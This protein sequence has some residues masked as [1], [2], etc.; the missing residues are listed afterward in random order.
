MINLFK[1][2]FRKKADSPSDRYEICISGSGGQG[3]ILAG[4][5]L[6]KAA[7]KDGKN[8]VQTQSYGP[9]SRGGASRCEVVVSEG[10]IDYPKLMGVDL[11]L[12]LTQEALTKQIPNL[13]A[14]A[15]T[16]YDS[17]YIKEPPKNLENCFAIPFTQLAM[18]EF[19]NRLVANM[20]ALG[21]LVGI[22]CVVSRDA[23]QSAL[24]SHVRES[25]RD[26]NIKALLRGFEEADRHLAE[27]GNK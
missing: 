6:A 2:F 4:I 19:Q 1:K 16:I 5:I 3:I 9:E 22:S 12:A 24:I 17:V 18:S 15:I 25:F 26:L 8:A 21:A 23:V 10:E 13:K 27:K 7:L 11:L 20:I 14:G